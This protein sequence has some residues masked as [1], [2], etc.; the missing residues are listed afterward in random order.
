MKKKD[1][2]LNDIFKIIQQA[3]IRS[4]DRTQIPH[5]CKSTLSTEAICPTTE[6]ERDKKKNSI[7]IQELLFA[8]LVILQEKNNPASYCML[9]EQEILYSLCL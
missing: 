8:Q 4:K 5:F 7:W 9:K 2:K 3:S 1:R 6:R